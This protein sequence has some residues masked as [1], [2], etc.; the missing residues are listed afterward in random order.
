MPCWIT[1]PE[2]VRP[3]NKQ[4]NL[5]KRKRE[6]T[7]GREGEISLKTRGGHGSEN[8][9]LQNY[10]RIFQGSVCSQRS[11]NLYKIGADISTNK[12]TEIK[13]EIQRILAEIRKDS[14]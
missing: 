6:K 3:G 10:I 12:T 14:Q 2:S 1:L 4:W 13:A 7:F 5:L 11:Q 9:F 8:S